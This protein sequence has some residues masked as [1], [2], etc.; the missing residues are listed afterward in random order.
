MRRTAAKNVGR[1]WFAFVLTAVFVVV[2]I[3]TAFVADSLA[4]LS[5]AAHMAT[6]AVSIALT[7][8]AIVVANRARRDGMR[9]FGLFRLEILAALVNAVLLFASAIYVLIE[10]VL[11]LVRD[12]LDVKAG[13]MLVV[14]ILGLVVNIVVFAL[15]RAGARDNLAMESAYTDAIADAAGSVGVIVAAVVVADRR[16]GSDR[17]DRRRVDRGL[18]PPARGRSES[19]AIRVLLQVA[20]EHVDL[21]EIRDELLA[22]PGVVDV[23]DLHVWTLT[24][25]ME[26]ATAHV[27]IGADADAHAV[28]DQ[29]QSLL[30]RPRHRARDHPGR[31]RRPRRVRR[32]QLVTADGSGTFGFVARARRSPQGLA[33][34]KRGARG[35]T[36]AEPEVERD[37]EPG[38]HVRERRRDLRVPERRHVGEPAGDEEEDRGDQDER[39]GGVGAAPPHPHEREH[40]RAR[41]RRGSRRSRRAWTRST[42]WSRPRARPRARDRSPPRAP[43]PTAN[44]ARQI[45]VRVSTN[46][47]DRDHERDHDV[48]P[49]R[50]RRHPQE[51]AGRADGA[52]VGAEL[53]RPPVDRR[54]EPTGRAAPPAGPRSPCSARGGRARSRW[55]PTTPGA[56]RAPPTSPRTSAACS[57]GCESG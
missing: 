45:R 11:R 27:M 17:P 50:R 37:E 46:T 4:L 44:A 28:L 7:L 20:P 56:R 53:H 6:D 5:D 47:P 26:V 54:G 21:D 52:A 25:E 13:P 2:E 8:A 29:A 18:D 19:R 1:L 41:R 30:R 33:Q 48:R 15:L 34:A 16:M 14:A 55:S 9:T 24:S 23:H 39:H 10:A 49:R 57:W 3:V 31:A 42:R 32:A 22:V 35:E 43:S 36:R 38:D 12:D 51:L 40:A